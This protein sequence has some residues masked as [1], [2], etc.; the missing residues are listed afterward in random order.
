MRA[1]VVVLLPHGPAHLDLGAGSPGA[2]AGDIL[3]HGLIED[4]DVLADQGHLPS[5]VVHRQ[6]AQIGPIDFYAALERVIEAVEQIQ[7][8]GFSAAAFARQPEPEV[9]R[10]GQAEVAQHDLVAESEGDVFEA[11]P[12]VEPGQGFGL[13]WF[14]DGGLFAEDLL[15]SPDADAGLFEKDVQAGQLFD[16]LEKE[17]DAGQEGRQIAAGASAFEDV[18]QQQAQAQ[19]RD[20]FEDR[21]DQFLG[22]H[23]FHPGVDDL[24]GSFAEADELFVFQA[25]RFDDAD[26]AEQFHQLAGLVDVGQ[27]ASPGGA[28]RLSAEDHQG[29]QAAGQQDHRPERQF[30]ILQAQAG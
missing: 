8:G 14:L 13:G 17:D 16:R 3:R 12:V 11:D 24:S 10:H 27:K 9:A 22:L 23:P 19:H 18:E 29:K 2:S 15:E 30:P 4:H 1:I 5:Q 21:V 20:D 28:A 26:A 25:E 7:H 6:L